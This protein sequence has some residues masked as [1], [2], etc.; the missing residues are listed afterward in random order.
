MKFSIYRWYSLTL[1]QIKA[2]PF[3]QLLSWTHCQRNRLCRKDFN[4]KYLIRRTCLAASCV[5][6]RVCLCCIQGSMKDSLDSDTDLGPAKWPGRNGII[7]YNC[8]WGLYFLC[9]D[10]L[11]I[12][13]SLMGFFTGCIYVTRSWLWQ[14]QPSHQVYGE[15]FV[16]YF[17]LL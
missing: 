13:D 14:K 10:A 6:P 5:V 16:A 4:A 8:Y 15:N 12:P 1:K 17:F 7:L 11:S 2:Q 9:W 3:I